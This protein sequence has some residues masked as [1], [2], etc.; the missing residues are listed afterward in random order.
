MSAAISTCADC[1][2]VLPKSAAA[3]HAYL[4]GSGECWSL[5]EA[6]LER[7]YQDPAYMSVHRITVDAYAAQHPGR[8]EPRTIQSVNLHLVGLHLALERGLDPRFVRRALARLTGLKRELFWLDPP[9][10][11]G[12]V[13]V[14]HVARAATPEDHAVRVEAW[15][16]S[17][18][19]A[20]SPHHAR[21]RA[22]GAQ[23]LSGAG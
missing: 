10:S 14:D 3:P 6:V 7:E 5:F 19:E 12:E 20:W 9:P 23:I 15:G 22:L 8:A 21:I 18:F 1:G 16:W 2:L 17:V 4:G 11:L 13:R